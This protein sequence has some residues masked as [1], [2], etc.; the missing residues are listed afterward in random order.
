MIFTDTMTDKICLGGSKIFDI[1][2]KSFLFVSIQYVLL[3][4]WSA[5]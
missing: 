3:F 2:D 5:K 4:K 1:S